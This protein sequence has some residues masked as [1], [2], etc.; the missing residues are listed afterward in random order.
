MRILLTGGRLAETL[1]LSRLLHQLG[2]QVI[3]ADSL[4]YNFT[5]L[6]CSI[7]QSYSIPP[8][9]K[10]PMRFAYSLLDIIRKEAISLFIPTCEEL[11]TVLRYETLLRPHVEI[12]APSFKNSLAAL[13]P[14]RFYDWMKTIQLP[15][16]P[17]FR[18][19]SISSIMSDIQLHGDTRVYS[20]EWTSNP[21]IQRNDSPKSI[22]CTPK[23]PWIGWDGTHT[24]RWKSYS[25]IKQGVVLFH[26]TYEHPNDETPQ[27]ERQI[28][29]WITSFA[30]QTL[31]TGQLSTRFVEH[32]N[33][34]VAHTC[35]PEIS[36]G[37]YSL[38]G[39]NNGEYVIHSISDIAMNV[40]QG[41]GSSFLLTDPIPTIG[42]FLQQLVITYRSFQRG[43][44]KKQ[45]AKFD[46]E[47]G[48]ER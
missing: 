7:R 48:V 41:L 18:F 37:I 47:W 19:T 33:Q 35:S 43:I 39:T 30:K 6:S 9:Q 13:S 28:K 8:A 29:E 44:S 38:E 31:Y 26:V 11:Y 45:G 46:I 10:E 2:A 27:A 32:N 14:F 40:Q 12:F 23:T 25:W 22:I 42:S 20:P 3:V 21:I 16:L 4:P 24:K 17:V 36:D 1:H 15:T 34:I 5:S